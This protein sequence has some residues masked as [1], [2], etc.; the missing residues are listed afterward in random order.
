MSGQYDSILTMEKNKNVA[1]E[2]STQR[3]RK[4]ACDLAGFHMDFEQIAHCVSR[5]SQPFF[6][7][8][9]CGGAEVVRAAH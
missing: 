4:Q 1:F 5:A 3:S 6:S 2:Q 8:M 7:V 9:Q